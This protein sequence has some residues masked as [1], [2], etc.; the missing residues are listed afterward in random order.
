MRCSFPVLLIHVFA[1]V[2]SGNDTA[3]HTYEC[4]IRPIFR[5]H[6][7]DCHGATEKLEGG[8]DL[9]LVRFL[10]RGGESGP[11]ISTETPRESYLLERV[12]TGEMPPGETRVPDSEIAIIE[13]WIASGAPTARPEPE[14]IG[15]GLG[16]TKEE[17]S[18]GSPI[19]ATT[20]TTDY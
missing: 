6:C 1:L 20:G 4:D 2:A 3:M 12:R 11:A 10:R 9:R 15:P 14:T 19:L 17:L 18:G 5:A 16:I 8:L 13:Q 7:F